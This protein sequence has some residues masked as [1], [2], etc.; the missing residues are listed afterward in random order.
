MFKFGTRMLPAVL[1]RTGKAL[2]FTRSYC[3]VQEEVSYVYHKFSKTLYAEKQAYLLTKTQKLQTMPAAVKR[4]QE[5]IDAK[6]LTGPFETLILEAK[7][8]ESQ[9]E[10]HKRKKKRRTPLEYPYSLMQNFYRAVACS[11]ASKYPHLLDLCVGELPFIT[12]VWERYGSK[13][14]AHGSQASFLMAKTPLSR[15]YDDTTVKESANVELET[16]HPNPP[17]FDLAETNEQLP[18]TYLSGFKGTPPFPHL[19]TMILIDVFSWPEDQI[20]QKALIYL[21]THLTTDLTQRQGKQYG[22]ILEEP[23]AAQAIVTNGKR[24][25]FI[26]YQLNTLDLRDDSGI[27]NLVYVES[28]PLLYRKIKSKEDD[29]QKYLTEMKEQTLKLL[30]TQLLNKP[31]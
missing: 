17:F 4:L 22:D 19:H 26:W 11:H 1:Q 3:D 27:K 21:F 10:L 14:T 25:H 13:V 24:F 7:S 2:M 12:N 30:L 28:P 29:K 8:Y 6:S 20:V 5:S 16:T 9:L 15:F 18:K 23:V 31:K